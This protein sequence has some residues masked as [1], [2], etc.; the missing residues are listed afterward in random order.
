MTEFVLFTL[1]WTV[2]M[3][4]VVWRLGF[5]L[6]LVVV[7]VKLAV[8]VVLWFGDGAEPFPLKDGNNYYDDGRDIV[9]LYTPATVLTTVKGQEKLDRIAGYG[10]H[11]VYGWWNAMLQWLVGDVRL[12][13]PAANVLFA[14]M[15]ALLLGQLALACGLGKSYANGLVVLALLYPDTLTWSSLTNTKDLMISLFV[16]L[17][18]LAIARLRTA[19]EPRWMLALLAALAFLIG[20]RYYLIP[21]I[22]GSAAVVALLGRWRARNVWLLAVLIL[23]G[24]SYIYYMDPRF[25]IKHASRLDLAEIPLGTINFLLTPRPWSIDETYS[26]LLASSL[27]HWIMAVPAAIGGILLWRAIP[28]A[29]PALVF[30][31]LVVLFYAAEESLRGP[32]QRVQIDFILAWAQFHFFF[33]VITNHKGPLPADRPAVQAAGP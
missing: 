10:P 11:K 8:F 29:R 26:F 12:A 16:V 4:I 1:V 27:W 18:F 9:S 6:A 3:M 30:F 22:L 33:H 17:A 13:L 15:A 19:L 5:R 21:L 25:L 28:G 24:S 7:T 20:L 32:R 23:V 14:T 2:M 31:A